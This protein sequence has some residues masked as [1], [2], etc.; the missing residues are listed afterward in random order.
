M[1]NINITYILEM[2]TKLILLGNKRNI[3]YIINVM[4]NVMSK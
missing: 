2:N 1:R 3:K 4:N